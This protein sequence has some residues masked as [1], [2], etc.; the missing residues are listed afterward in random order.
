MPKDTICGIATAPG[1]GGIAIVRVSGPLSRE[2]LEECF[3]PKC[4]QAF[5]SRRMMYGYAVNSCGEELDEVMAVF[6]AAPATYTREDMF[7]IQCHGGGV[8]ARRVM[9]RIIALGARIADP[10]EFTKRAFLNGRID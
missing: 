1:A 10:G 6:L 9:E 8:C 2:I 3:H 5:A 7:E 4:A